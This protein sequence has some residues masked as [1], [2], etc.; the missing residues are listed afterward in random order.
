MSVALGSFGEGN[1]TP[2]QYSCLENLYK[3]KLSE[4]KGGVRLSYGILIW[5]FVQVLLVYGHWSCLTSLIRLI[6]EV[7]LVS[8]QY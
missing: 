7:I 3:L 8:F 6:L 5:Y 1:G 2:L 4:F